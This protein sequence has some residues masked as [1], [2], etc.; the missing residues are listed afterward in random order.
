MF[1]GNDETRW[2][3][4]AVFFLCLFEK[5]CTA[6][7]VAFPKDWLDLKATVIK[8]LNVDASCTGFYAVGLLPAHLCVSLPFPFVFCLYTSAN[9][10][11]YFSA[12]VSIFSLSFSMWFWH[13]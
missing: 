9:N 8:I 12:S 5:V 4:T 7:V 6:F 2:V 3:I 10:L 1:S 11:V 13:D